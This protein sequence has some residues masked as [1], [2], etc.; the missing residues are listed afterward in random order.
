MIPGAKVLELPLLDDVKIDVKS[1]FT[2]FGEML[3][4]IGQIFGLISN[5]ESSLSGGISEGLLNLKNNF[6]IPKWNK[7]DPLIINLQL[8]FFTKTDSY[9]DVVKPMQELIKMTILSKDPND[10]TRFIVPGISLSTMSDFNEQ[11]KN[12][13]KGNNSQIR[14]K[15]CAIEIPGIIYLPLAFLEQAQPT[16]SK[17]ITESGNPLW[18][19]LDC[20]FVSV[21]PA[22][23]DMFEKSIQSDRQFRIATEFD[24][25]KKKSSILG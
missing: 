1:Q 16:Y 2:S 4:Q 7:T 17:Q 9:Y 3:P 12:N 6:D 15:I 23:T 10:D 19:T 18:G 11:Q 25:A 5:V 8:G 14:A 22:T 13:E 20:Q 21:S 24:I